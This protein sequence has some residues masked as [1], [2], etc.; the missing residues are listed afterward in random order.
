MTTVDHRSNLLFVT[1]AGPQKPPTLLVRTSE[2]YS[3]LLIKETERTVSS[4]SNR[5]KGILC[6]TEL[7]IL[8]LNWAGR[9]P[10][11]LD[12]LNPSTA[13]F[14]AHTSLLRPGPSCLLEADRERRREEDTTHEGNTVGLTKT[15]R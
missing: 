4:G 7:R 3:G 10:P 12:L 15:K 5:E 9:G 8:R 13:T 2:V 1:R 6:T 14:G 11:P